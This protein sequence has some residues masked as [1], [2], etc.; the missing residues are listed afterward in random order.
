M[1]V[2]AAAS[3]AFAEGARG[4]PLTPRD[5]AAVERAREGAARRLEDAACRRVFSD[6][7]DARGR[8]IERNLEEWAVGP[9]E[10]LRIVPFVDGSGQL[11]CQASK[12]M[13][14][15]TPSVPRVTVCPGFAKLQQDR[16]RLAES[17]IIHELLHTL[18]LGENPPT[19]SEITGQ[20][21]ERCR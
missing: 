10:Y 3:P 6:F 21:E 13:L 18:G 9:A 12:V 20:V 8:T 5:A 7:R 14:V 19:S 1:T 17:L 16:P 2:V 11:L 4:A 15:S